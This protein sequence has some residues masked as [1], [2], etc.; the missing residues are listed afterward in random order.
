MT[1]LLKQPRPQWIALNIILKYAWH[2]YA[3]HNLSSGF[4]L[5]RY[6]LQNFL[7]S[8]YTSALQRGTSFLAFLTQRIQ[9]LSVVK[10]TIRISRYVSNPKINA[11]TIIK[12]LFL[13]VR[14]IT[15]L[16]QVKRYCSW[17]R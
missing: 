10:I 2:G 12:F 5:S 4:F 17:Y 16:K 1:N 13:F 8:A 6:T 9:C 14:N 15:C 7:S 3:K 11:D